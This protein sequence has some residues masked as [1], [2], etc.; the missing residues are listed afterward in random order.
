MRDLIL[1]RK[2]VRDRQNCDI[3]DKTLLTSALPSH[4]ALP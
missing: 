1:G 4:I 2:F 3:G